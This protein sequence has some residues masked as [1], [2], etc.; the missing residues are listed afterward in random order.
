[1]KAL[2]NSVK[3]FLLSLCK[4]LGKTH[5]KLIT[6]LRQPKWRHG[7][8]SALC[9]AGFLVVLVIVNICVQTLESAYGW[10]QDYSFN[11]YATTGQQTENVLKRLQFP[12][13]IYLLYQNGDV[14]RPLLELL[15]RYAV[16]SENVSVLP[17]DIIQNPGILVRFVGTVTK[18]IQAGS[19]I[20]H[21]EETDQYKVLDYEDFAMR[22]YNIE[23][24]TFEY[25]GIAYEKR[26]TEALVYVTEN[27]IPVVGI[28]QGHGEL[29]PEALST[30]TEFLA[31]N[32][33]DC[34]EIK[35]LSQENLNE[36]D[37]LLIAGPQKDF[38]QNEL[39]KINEFVQRGG[40]LFIMRDFT[41]PIQLPNYMSLLRNYGIHPMEGMVVAG[42]KDE[43]SYYGER[44]YLLPYM[45]QMDMTL[46]LMTGR[47]TTLL[48]APASAFE[49]PPEPS[50]SLS[51]ATV[52]KTGPTAYIRATT[53]Q[54]T[55]IDRQEGDPTGELSLALYGHR[56]HA[57]GNIS[58]V[59][60]IGNS[61]LFTDEYL[62]QSTHNEEFIIQVMAELLPQKSI[63]L[64]I[65]ASSAVYPGLHPGGQGL[66]IA[67]LVAVPLL[68]LVVSLCVLLP[69]R[70]R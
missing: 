6:V 38:S 42:E 49:S 48:L 52:L 28:L 19:V 50:A 4:G 1:M 24:G 66:G 27:S 16:L 5:T 47:L 15:N 18:A 25:T 44:L 34:R 31:S 20:V 67:L 21:C 36:V 46:P 17:T 59:F 32:N 68:T 14:D 43:G 33:Y 62:Y 7:R 63:S 70:N 41:D 64:D 12:V 55:S 23:Q 53:Q 30:F 56:M 57:T 39:K 69:R 10:R 45:N 13:K 11:G 65:M 37:L 26:L 9:L 58:R 60:A 29:T 2:A 54:S 3:Q 40:S 51:I 35:L 8:L 61:S 22:E